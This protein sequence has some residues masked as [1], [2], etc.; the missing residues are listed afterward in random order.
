MI[1]VTDLCKSFETE[2][3]VV[4]D[5]SFSVPA[6]Q[7]FAL[8][9]ANGA[10]KTTTLKILATLKNATS[11][12]CFVA[13]HNV[14]KD[15]EKVRT[16]IGYVGQGNSLDELS[17]GKENMYEHASLFGLNDEETEKNYASLVELFAL[18]EHIDNKCSTYSGGYS[19]RT[20]IA[21]ALMHRP[22]VLILDEPTTGLDPDIRS[23]MWQSLQ[24]LAK[25]QGVTIIFSTHYLDEAD[26]Y[27]D[28]IVIME[29]G[30]LIAKG[31]P[32][33]LKNEL[34]GDS[35]V[36]SLAQSISEEIIQ[37]LNNLP[38]V[39]QAGCIGKQL[40]I[41]STETAKALPQIMNLLQSYDCAF[42]KIAISKPSL[43]EVYLKLAGKQ[44]EVGKVPEVAKRSWSDYNKE[45]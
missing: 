9:G 4:D 30:K 44:F 31:S 23:T 40:L 12:D 33:E 34:D 15:S 39:N 32:E 10:G 8:L 2:T 11:G 26:K 19:R 14:R 25:E 20:Q 41:T 35:I 29:K 43:D 13:D 21:I 27:A 38:E 17:S 5:L 28:Q 42:E 3:K 36:L 7:I 45:K 16:R 37:E 22:D 24:H 6:G 18:S 1:K